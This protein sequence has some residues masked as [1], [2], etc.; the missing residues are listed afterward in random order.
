[1][2]KARVLAPLALIAGGGLLLARPLWPQ[3]R[4]L[5]TGVMCLAAAITT[6][7]AAGTFGAGPG[8]NPKTGESSWSG[9]F[10]QSHGGV[11]GESIYQVSRRLVQ[12]VGV[13]ILVVFLA[14][15]GASLLTGISP[16][17]A[18]RAAAARVS[19]IATLVSRW[20]AGALRGHAQAPTGASAGVQDGPLEG[21][22]GARATPM[23][24]APPEPAPSELVVRATHVEAPSQDRPELLSGEAGPG[25]SRARRRR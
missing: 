22:T 17:R 11:V 5:R 25:R 1:M 13:D 2:G 20:L 15:A 18:L 16:A 9:V 23:Q 7:L 24:L 21:L 12:S 14:L 8:S 6:A 10:L 19:A 3:L 4:P